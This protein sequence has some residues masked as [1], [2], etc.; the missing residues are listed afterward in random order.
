MDGHLPNE[1][2]LYFH[3]FDG[4]CM[5]QLVFDAVVHEESENDNDE[6]HTAG[7]NKWFIFNNCCI[8]ISV[9]N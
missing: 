3:W 1:D 6:N 4:D 5:P 8:Q 2:T 9:I 7:E